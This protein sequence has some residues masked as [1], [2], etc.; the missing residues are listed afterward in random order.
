MLWWYDND[1][2]NDD[3]DNDD[4]KSDDDGKSVGV[5]NDWLIWYD[6]GDMV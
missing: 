2:N 6:E 1:K 4:D 3:D 5:D